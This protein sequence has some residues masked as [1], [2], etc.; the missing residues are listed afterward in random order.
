MAGCGH[1]TFSKRDIEKIVVGTPES[2][3]IKALGKGTEVEDSK[4]EKGFELDQGGTKIKVRRI[5][6]GKLMEW[7]QGKSYVYI[8]I[9][10]G[11]VTM[12]QMVGDPDA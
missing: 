3:V 10:K 8:T 6:P 2:E 9:D 12:K 1:Q 11:R 5:G 7:R 4:A